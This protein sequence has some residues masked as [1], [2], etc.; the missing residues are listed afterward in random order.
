MTQD[1]ALLAAGL[2]GLSLLIAT[3]YLLHWRFHQQRRQLIRANL[4]QLTLLRALV[5]GLQRHRGLSNGVLCG[6]RSLTEDLLSVRRGLDQQMGTVPSLPTTHRDGWDNLIDHW[7][8]LREGNA[9]SPVNNLQQH[10]HIIRNSLFLMEDIASEIDL[11]GGRPALGYLPCLWREVMQAAE[12]TGQARALGTGIAAAGESSAEQRV[13][14]R[15]LCEKIQALS[16][17]AFNTLRQHANTHP[18]P[19]GLHLD[20]SEQRVA[21]FLH[22]LE[23]ELL[24]KE[25]PVIAAKVFFHCATLAIDELLGVVDVGLGEL[26]VNRRGATSESGQ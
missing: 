20:Q 2:I 10:H 5:A 22:C 6:D 21:E 15:F 3:L 17:T 13:R 12:W 9:T 18:L 24:G 26:G 8:R 1:H 7:S 19:A 11:S 25:K 4:R 14:L 23:Q 16:Q